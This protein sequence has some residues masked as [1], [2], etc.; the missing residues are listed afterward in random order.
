[1]NNR[2]LEHRL[3]EW[4]Q[5]YMHSTG[6]QTRWG[7]PLVAIADARDPL[8]CT[9][10]RITHGDHLLPHN[11]IANARS[12][13]SYFLP[14]D[15]A[16]VHSNRGGKWASQAW[17]QAYIETNTLIPLLN[18]FLQ[19]I[20]RESGYDCQPRPPTHDFSSEKLMSRWSHK[21]VAFIAGLGTLGTHGM[22]ITEK[23]CSGRLGSLITTMPL[24]TTPRPRREYCLQHQGLTC[25]ACI[26]AC[27]HGFLQQEGLDAQG[28]YSILLAHARTFAHLQGTADVCGKCA[29]MGPCAQKMP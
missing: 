27:P 24:P 8:F 25:F 28:C 14:L 4:I 19:G 12:V 16:T 23:G 10:P 5:N 1:M 15:E 13:I 20:L 17:A 2:D 26:D 7:E 18:E 21:H 22:L 3:H 9:L 29:V 11:L 6:A